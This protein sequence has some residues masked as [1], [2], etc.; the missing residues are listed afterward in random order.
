MPNTKLFRFG[1]GIIILFLIILLGTKVRFIFRPIEVLFQTLF[2]P[3]LI[4]GVLYY[5]LRPIVQFLQRRRVPKALSILLIYLL[6]IGIG[7]VLV[8]W[9]G[10]ELQK[11]F[12]GLI[13]NFPALLDT[14][15]EKIVGLKE[16][17]WFSRFQQ[18]D[19]LTLDTVTEKINAYLS[20]N[21][22]DLGNK[23]TNILGII[24]NIV[25][26]AITVPF[27]LFYLLKDGQG[28]P[29]GVLRFLPYLQA[30]EAKKILKDMDTALS[31][32]IQ[33]QAIVSF[34]VGVMMYIGYLIIGIDYSLILATIA[35]L[36]NVIPFIGPFI[37]IIPALIIGFIAS[38]FMA[39]KVVIVAVVVQQ[40]DGNFSSPYIMGRKLDLHP[41]TII[42]LLLVA[43]SMAG[44]MG[45]I[46]AVPFY[47]VLKVIVSH[48]YRLYRLHKDRETVID[49]ES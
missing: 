43:G 5:L 26:I 30:T 7:T 48:T 41:L 44:L 10:P 36:T 2:F 14:L 16:N 34:I 8:L 19:Y 42:L 33:G 9:I 28:A 38:P 17:K 11:Q 13:D 22:S 4:S 25:T 21:V 47:A 29:N 39:I 35:M 27:I 18:N 49:I 31:S 6:F 23:I 1:Y 20:T 24:T 37:A 12:K 32:Y 15:R 45:M 46:L 40:I 3:F